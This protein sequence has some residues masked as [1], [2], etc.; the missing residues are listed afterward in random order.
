MPPLLQAVEPKQPDGG[1]PMARL[2]L[3][4]ILLLA[5]CTQIDAAANTDTQKRTPTEIGEQGARAWANLECATIA[6]FA[7]DDKNT[8]KLFTQG[9]EEGLEFLAGA[10]A[11]TDPKES[12]AI[13]DKVPIIMGWR[14]EGPSDD[15]M[16]GR[17]WEATVLYVADG[18]EERSQWTHEPINPKA[19]PV[20]PELRQVKAENRFR[21]RNCDLL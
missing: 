17:V 1:M 16:L 20:T 9:R 19:G 12:K 8:E 14:L 11:T 6:M 2:R 5:G 4:I 3:A 18:L 13:R 15:F 10:R 21:K 7:K